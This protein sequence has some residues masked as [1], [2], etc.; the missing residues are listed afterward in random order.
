MTRE[1]IRKRYFEW[2]C[3]LIAHNGAYFKLLEYLFN[4]DFEYII[5]MDDNR[6][7]DGVNLRYKFGRKVGYGDN[8]VA[9]LLD[10]TP[11]SVLEMM[12][13][14]AFRCE[15]QIMWNDDI[16]NRTGVWFWE[17]VKNLGLLSMTDRSFNEDR[18][19]TIIER[20]LERDYEPDGRGGLFAVEG[21]PKDMRS[22]EIWYQMFIFLEAYYDA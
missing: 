2:L 13:A 4:T 15:E 21:Y 9:T 10:V 8:M 7:C 6:A 18:V 22:I 14:L 12:A 20:F 17:M 3:D 19:R 16:G 11:C 5:P 1:R